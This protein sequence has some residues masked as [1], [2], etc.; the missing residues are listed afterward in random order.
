MP[1]RRAL[2]PLTTWHSQNGL[3]LVSYFWGLSY[4]MP[5]GDRIAFAE[6]FPE[7]IAA[8]LL[9]QMWAWGILLLVPAL[10][11]LIGD[12][13]MAHR[14]G[15]TNWPWRLSLYGHTLLCA[16]YGTLTFLALIQGAE[17]IRWHSLGQFIAALLSALS[18]P[19][20]WGFITYQHSTYARLPR[21][22]VIRTLKDDDEEKKEEET[23]DVN[24]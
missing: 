5:P 19:V 16:V 14:H 8:A 22:V 6:V 24:A 1:Y 20:L 13:V 21:P 23:P 12:R 17:E 15:A 11:A 2:P 9:P 4:L 10:G 3:L 18:R 7:R